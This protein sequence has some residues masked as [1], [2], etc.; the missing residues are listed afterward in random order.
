MK[1]INN[2]NLLSFLSD[3]L[4][5]IGCDSEEAKD[6]LSARNFSEGMILNLPAVCLIG[7]KDARKKNKF[8]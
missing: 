6:F 8:S 2:T 5:S 4:I 1:N 3:Y 7:K